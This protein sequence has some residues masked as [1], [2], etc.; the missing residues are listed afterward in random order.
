MSFVFPRGAISEINI[1]EKQVLRIYGHTKTTRSIEPFVLVYRITSRWPQ[2][3]TV[4][5]MLYEHTGLHVQISDSSIGRAILGIIEDN[6]GHY[7]SSVSLLKLCRAVKSGN[8]ESI[9]ISMMLKK[10]LEQ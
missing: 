4:E 2:E 6:H 8:A 9:L 1:D 5:W 10:E 3:S 7:I